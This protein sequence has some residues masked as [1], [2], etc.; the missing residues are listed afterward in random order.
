MADTRVYDSNQ[1]TIFLAAFPIA[2]GFADGEFC[3]IHKNADDFIMVVG[4][5]GSVTRSNSNDDSHE[6]TIT[7]MQSAAANN[8]LS[9]LRNLD[10]IT[11]GGA[12]IGPLLIR[13]R[14]GTSVYASA[15]AWI[16]GPPDVTFNR[17]AEGRA[18]KI[19]TSDMLRNDGGN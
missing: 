13:D 1:V 6:V 5:D 4:T 17:G 11:P 7:L 14:Q 15:H 2:G 16:A 12:G 8:L 19:H 10:K 9:A 18:W 3:K